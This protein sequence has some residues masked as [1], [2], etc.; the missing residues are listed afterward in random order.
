MCV[1]RRRT[2]SRRCRYVKQMMQVAVPP[3]CRFSLACLGSTTRSKTRSKARRTAGL[4]LVWCF[5]MYGADVWRACVA[6]GA[7][8]LVQND[9]LDCQ[10]HPQEQGRERLLCGLL[11]HCLLPLSPNPHPPT[12]PLSLARARGRV[13]TALLS[14]ACRCLVSIACGCLVGTALLPEHRGRPCLCPGPP[15]HAPSAP[16]AALAPRLSRREGGDGC[17]WRKQPRALHQTARQPDSQTARP[18]GRAAA[19]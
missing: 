18:Q 1:C 9:E 13:G 12:L 10:Q 19:A 17:G 4:Q 15:G 7:G 3:S 11:H 6:R 16:S 14:I 8:G 5:L 2:S